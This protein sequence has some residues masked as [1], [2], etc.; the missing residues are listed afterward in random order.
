MVRSFTNQIRDVINNSKLSRYAICKLANID[1]SHMSRFM[2]GS[3]S[4]STASLDRLAEVMSITIHA[5][6]TPETGGGIRITPRTRRK[7]E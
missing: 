2:S 7:K 1:Q 4:L 3:G 5:P 6:H